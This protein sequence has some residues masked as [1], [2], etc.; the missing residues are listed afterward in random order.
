LLHAGRPWPAPQIAPAFCDMPAIHG[1]QKKTASDGG[2]KKR[3]RL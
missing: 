2:S 3:M 1:G